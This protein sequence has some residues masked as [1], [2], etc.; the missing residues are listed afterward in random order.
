MKTIDKKT[1]NAICNE[2]AELAKTL[3]AKY[4]VTIDRGN[5]KYTTTTIDLKIKVE[6]K[7]E[8]SKKKAEA[9]YRLYCNMFG[10]QI[11]WFGKSFN[12]GSGNTLT[13]VGINPKAPKN[14]MQLDNQDGK[15]YVAPVDYVRYHMNK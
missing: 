5:A 4:G 11:E 14:C 2:I 3:E 12:D 8:A 15:R 10:A 13:V 9:T 7:G 6:L 1:C